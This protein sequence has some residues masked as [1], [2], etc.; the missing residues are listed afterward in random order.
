MSKTLLLA[1]DSST[2]QRV[3]E[4]TFAQE[5]IR[6]IS[7]ADG[8]QALKSID[9][10]RPD[11][12]LADV[13]M[14]RVDGY[15]VSSHVKTSATL[16][17]IPVLLLTGA[18]EP[19]DEARAKAARCDGVLVKPF[20]PRA[21]VT[22]VQELL[23]SARAAQDAAA[24][25]AAAPPNGH[26]AGAP[27]AP[28]HAVP[29]W[30]KP[31]PSGSAA[32][33][34]ATPAIDA[35]DLDQKLA[36]LMRETPAAVASAPPPS[37]AMPPAP[38]ASS[39]APEPLVL[40]LGSFTPVHGTQPAPL[41]PKVPEPLELT[42][43]PLSPASTPASPVPELAPVPAAAS[44]AEAEVPAPPAAPASSKV[45]LSSAFSALLAAEQAAPP[46]T[47]APAVADHA[48]EDVV[49]RVLLNDKAVRKLVLDAAERMVKEEIERIKSESESVEG[50]PGTE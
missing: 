19:V 49:R 1:D 44:S 24:A 17:H 47:A 3:V 31:E 18:F 30:Y 13:G 43:M 9:R 40:D 7:V 29:T 36:G 28:G 20:E 38:A 35:A 21:L 10:E 37:A 45:S 25:A 14:P 26:D 22:R 12:V 4:L 46:G 41:E 33:R 32:D 48:L 39:V 15:S 16:Q 2:I 27:A 42:P 23:N 8:E 11:I 50:E 6:V 5:D 34:P